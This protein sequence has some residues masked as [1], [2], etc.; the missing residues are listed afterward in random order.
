ML[1]W[2][3][4]SNF[5]NQM[6]PHP[7]FMTYKDDINY[8]IKN[9]AVGMFLE[10][11]S[12]TDLMDFG[13]MRVW[14][15]GH[16]L[17]DPSL[18]QETLMMDFLNGYY[19]AAGIHLRQY[20][21]FIHDTFQKSGKT[22]S[23]FTKKSVHWLSIA[24]IIKAEKFFD[25]ALKAVESDEVL[26]ER[27]RR[28]RISL[29]NAAL[30][31]YPYL[32]SINCTK[33]IS[34]EKWR[35]MADEVS[36]FAK[37]HFFNRSQAVIG[38]WNYRTRFPD[39][40]AS[41]ASVPAKCQNL[42]RNKYV[43]YQEIMFCVAGQNAAK[44]QITIVDDPNASNGKAAKITGP[45]PWWIQQ[46]FHLPT[47]EGEKWQVVI[48]LRMD[49]PLQEKVALYAGY[50]DGKKEFKHAR[51]SVRSIRTHKYIDLVMPEIPAADNV[52]M[53]INP[54]AA[55]TKTPIYIDRITLIRK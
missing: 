51:I 39:M 50:Y 14:V 41:K 19:G 26:T 11:D 53:F 17:W 12:H 36:F 18:D 4:V 49:S 37:K 42:P 23:C 46:Q 13:Q 9:R 5:G 47:I 7:T 15:L 29:Y 16:L 48:S 28:S 31:Q 43:D 44:P 6:T 32:E 1:V 35:Y 33:M 30:L 40:L 38:I 22:V 8:Y 25:S 45:C 2:H 54:V 3:Y 10:G 27:V 21:Q 52:Y 34:Q 20:L 24:D 55:T